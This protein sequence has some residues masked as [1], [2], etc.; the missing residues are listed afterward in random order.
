V[1]GGVLFLFLYDFIENCKWQKASDLENY[2]ELDIRMPMLE[3]VDEI[4]DDSRYRTIN[5]D[6]DA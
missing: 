4:F 5:T 3:A 2:D 1:P 6:G